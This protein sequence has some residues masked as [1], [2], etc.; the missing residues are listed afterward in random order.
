MNQNLKHSLSD[1]VHKELG[2]PE[3]AEIFQPSGAGSRMLAELVQ[4]KIQIPLSRMVSGTDVRVGILSRNPASND[5]IP[6]LAIVCEFTRP[7]SVEIIR[8]AHRLVWNFSHAPMLI[9]LE[10]HQIR[11]WTC[12]EHP[13][14]QDEKKPSF[15]IEEVRA[16]V[17]DQKSLA[18]Q[19]VQSLHW[20]ELVTGNFFEK[21]KQRFKRDL[22]ADRLLLKNLKEVRKILVTDQKL[23]EDVC[24]DLLARIIF[25]Q[26]LI[27]RKD[28]S[29]KS[30]LSES[31]F[32]SL[33]KYGIISK[34][35]KNFEDLLLNYNDTYSLF[36]W[37]NE[38]FNGDL[39]PGDNDSWDNE[40]KQVKEEHL[41]T[42]ADFIAG[43]L[44]FQKKQGLLWKQYSFDVIPLEFISSIY[45][46]FVCSK[47][48]SGTVYTP[49]HLVDFILDG[50]LPWNGREWDIK[51][52]DPACGS[53]IFLVKAFQRLVW[54]WKNS[55]KQKPDTLIL[56]QLLTK[57]LFGVDKNEH[58]V[59]VASFSLYLAMCDEIDPKHY[60]VS[61]KFPSLTG[62]RVI[63]SDFFNEN[64][65][66]FRTKEDAHSY[67]LVIGN[68]P[69]GKGTL[70][71][72][73]VSLFKEE[74]WEIANKSI[75]TMFLPKAA[76]LTKNNGNVSMLQSSG[77]LTNNTG[78]AERFRHKLFNSFKIEEVINLSALRF[79]LIGRPSCVI[80]FKPDKPNGEPFV[81]IFPKELKTIDDDLR[82]VIEPNDIHQI[83]QDDAGDSIIWS[84][85]GWGGYRELALIRRLNKNINLELLSRENK[86]SKRQWI[87]RGDRKR[88]NIEIT[89]RRILDTKTFS[90]RTFLYI[91]AQYLPNNDDPF[92]HSKD[93][94]DYESAFKLPQIIIKQGWQAENQRFESAIVKSQ[95]NKGILC[96][97]SYIS[98]NGSTEILET[99]CL[100]L[101]SRFATFYLLLTSGRMATYIPTVKVEDL[102]R[103]PLPEIRPNLLEK[104]SNYE[105]LDQR[106]REAFGFSDSEWVLIDDLF[107][108]TLPD[109]KGNENSPGRLP[110]RS[111]N[112]HDTESFLKEYADYCLRTLKSGFGEDKNISAIIFSEDDNHW[113]PV[114]L[115]AFYLDDIKSEITVEKYACVRLREILMH[116]DRK[117]SSSSEQS[118]FYRRVARIYDVTDRD[119]KRVPTVYLIKPDRRR[120]WTKTA[121]MRDADNIAA[122]IMTWQD[123]KL[124]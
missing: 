115:M 105:K 111:E 82:I 116:Y 75:G 92:V 89:D 1:K 100:V 7:V 56:K 52:L 84:A 58:A 28:S 53:G 81:Y 55:E 40:K 121:A 62:N 117:L 27:D 110:T 87:N 67:D 99:A 13:K 5:T 11:A 71:D 6:P 19:A 95:D 34:F 107:D 88:K 64:I 33:K 74:G 123:N 69:W 12:Y 104:I 57:N 79:G 50:V 30:A 43:R 66:G 54:R 46:E 61:V 2:W 51:I 39:F 3:P 42:L 38:R 85:L 72:S 98:V 96:S 49:P 90:K 8:E 18:E 119:G 48:E 97:Q 80:T 91:D 41:R 83:Y 44:D 29:G 22:C 73:D 24:H 32:A 68:P 21:H 59:R 78:T 103:V 114:R 17:S 101:N 113:L 70:N 26:F 118:A 124:K 106:V 112:S 35:Y 76:K 47:N 120:Y 10:P 63:A 45:E 65:P 25:I 122:D 16:D 77:L 14:D 93:S 15:E 108:Y 60:L 109:F 36:R 23:N 4:R 9:T 37:L 31:K 86:I 20:I 94:N 102:L